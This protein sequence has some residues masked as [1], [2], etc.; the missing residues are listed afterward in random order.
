MATSS[1]FS[2]LGIDDET[3]QKSE[4]DFIKICFKLWKSC[5]Q[6]IWL[7]TGKTYT[8]LES[9]VGKINLLRHV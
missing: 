8:E 5:G 9:E 7:N 4:M 1:I 2:T 6:N 3:H